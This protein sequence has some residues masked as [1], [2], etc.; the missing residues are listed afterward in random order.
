MVKDGDTCDTFTNKYP[1]VTLQNLVDWNSEIGDRCQYLWVDYYVRWLFPYLNVSP[2]SEST[3]QDKLTIEQI[4]TGISGWEPTGTT[5]SPTP[6]STNGVVTPTPT[7]PGMVD[8]CDAFHLV[9]SGDNCATIAGDYQITR[10]QFLE[11]NPGVG[12]GCSSLWLEYYV[13]VSVI[14][15]DPTGTTTTS[16]TASP[17]NGI[18]TP[19][20]TLPGMVNNCD[21]FHMVGEGDQCAAIAKQYGITL[22]QLVEYNPEV[23]ADCTGLWLGYYVCVSVIGVDPSS[24]ITPPPTTTPTNGIAT[25]TPIRPGMVDNCDTFYKVEEG[26]VCSDIAQNY[27]I[28]LGQ[29]VK[30]NPE[31][32]ADCSGLWLGYY[33]CVSIIGDSPTPPTTTSTPTNGVPTPTPTRPGMVSNCDAFYKVESGD[34]CGVIAKNHGIS[35][36]QLYK[37]NTEIG[38]DCSGL[39][40]DYYICVSVIGVDPIPTTTNGNGVAT[41]TP[42]QAGMTGNCNE[43]HKVV[44]GD[45][46]VSIAKNAGISLS[47]FYAWNKGVGSD[48]KSLWLS[49]YVCIGVL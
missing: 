31:V 16:T 1:G 44:N 38:T 19:T 11:W 15:Q 32:N 6:T 3:G 2:R 26:D 17:T 24:T 48:C 36:T 27:G 43:F 5:T 13:C 12:A 42:T 23:K 29:F 47:S 22:S 49:Y 34:E 30:Y 25:P 4:C 33:V 45:N 7:Q 40:A 39:W 10:D 21:V 14:G 8:N 20:P 35:L 28:T 18:S 37:W 9:Q 46:C 41:P